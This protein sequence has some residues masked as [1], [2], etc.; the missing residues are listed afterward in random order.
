M[1]VPE[2]VERF[3]VSERTARRHRARGTLPSDSRRKAYRQG[4][5]LT[6]PAESPLNMHATYAWK[7]LTIARNAIRNASRSAKV[8]LRDIQL[9]LQIYDDIALLTAEMASA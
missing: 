5:V 9:A 1:S 2:I 3:G 8:E 4:R 6:M 7:Q